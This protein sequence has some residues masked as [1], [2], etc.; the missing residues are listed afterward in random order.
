MRF[1]IPFYFLAVSVFLLSPIQALSAEQSLSSCAIC[2]TD[3]DA[4]DELT[5]AAIVD[6]EGPDM[7]D[8]QLGAGC[9]VKQAPFDLYEKVLVDPDFLE[10]VHGKVSCEKCHGGDPTSDDPD[11]AHEGMV[12]DPSL[13]NSERACGECHDRIVNTA[14]ESLHSIAD[15]LMNSLKERCSEEQWNKLNSDDGLKR[16]CLSC[17]NNSCGTCHVSRPDITGGGLNNGHMFQAKP[18]FI[19]QC[20]ACHTIPIAGDFFG[21][22]SEGDVHYRDGRMVCIDCHGGEEMHASGKKVKDRYH[23]PELPKCIDCHQDLEQGPIRHHEIHAGLVD[24]TVC[25][26]QQYMN[27]ATCHVGTDEDG[28]H[29]TQSMS[30]EKKLIIGLNADKTVPGRNHEYVL[31][32]QVGLMPDTFKNYIEGDMEHFT[33]LPNY[34]RTTPH[35]IQRKTWQNANCNHCHGQR[36]IFLTADDLTGLELEANKGVIVPDHRLPK[37]IDA[38]KPL[39]LKQLVVNNALKVDAK[40]LKEHSGDEELI[41]LDV[42][43]RNEYEDGHIPGAILLCSC[44]IRTSNVANPPF[45]M[46]S[47]E[48]LA[49]L[50]GDVGISQDTRVVLYDGGHNRT[51]TMFLALEL[52]GHKKLSFLDG[53]ISNWKK[54]GFPIEE[55]EVKEVKPVKYQPSG[56]DLLADSTQI[57]H[58]MEKGDAVLIDNRNVSQHVGHTKRDKIV[59]KPGRIP[60][61]YNVPLKAMMDNNGIMKSVEELTWLLAKHHIYKGMDEVVITTCNTNSLAAEFYMILRYLGFDNVKV[62]DG[63]WAEWSRL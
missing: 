18:D 33:S 20:A 31:V 55:G 19:Y 37:Q 5:S 38:I 30:G 52:M 53:N 35:N 54:Q 40:W 11:K 8:L 29:Y 3:D 28:I 50:F 34:K 17:H 21:T 57:R 43:T 61:S 41:I 60:G 6:A 48:Q 45:M 49:K 12:R 47:M 13:E 32:R 24:C 39:Q 63:S 25:H 26:S 22:Y 58:L 36:D 10:S 46:Q 59:K 14:K 42:R 62:H 2:H 7:S 23:L 15:P 4:I 9:Q 51:G 16:Q 56:R 1:R 44:H 27:C